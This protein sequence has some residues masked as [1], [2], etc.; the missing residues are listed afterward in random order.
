MQILIK[1]QKDSSL[2]ELKNIQYGSWI[3]LIAPKKEELE[4]IAKKTGAPLEFLKSALD[5]DEKP[6]IEKDSGTVMVIFKVPHERNDQITTLPLTAIIT[7]NNIITI[8]LKKTKIHEDFEES[9]VKGFFTNKKTRFLL[10]LF[11]CSSSRY[12]RYLDKIEKKMN[13]IEK[14]LMENT[15]NY[16]IL[17]FL[18]LQKTMVYF[19]TAIISN[20]NIF[21]RVMK[22]SIV[23]LYEDDQDLLEDIIIENRQALD[24]VNTFTD[25]LSKTT[26]AYASVASNNLNRV[27][28]FLTSVTILFSLPTIVAS[29]WG[30]NVGLPLQSNP[31]AFPLIMLLTVIL[32]A[33]IAVIFIKKGWF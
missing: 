17:A 18:N 13:E 33:L 16:D 8:C 7:K 3:N 24:M 25:I 23:R 22:G 2:R 29:I 21:D 12:L 1:T 28:K 4:N 9:K 31:L 6:R 20:V 26:D 11:Y 30:M 27:V 14:N 32:A 19:K 10:Q 15:K 5:E